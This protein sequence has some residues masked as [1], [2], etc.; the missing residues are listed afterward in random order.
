MITYVKNRNPKIK[1]NVESL[2]FKEVK[3]YGTS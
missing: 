2:K 1:F 3:Y